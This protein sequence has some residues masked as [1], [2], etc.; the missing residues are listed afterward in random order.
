MLAESLTNRFVGPSDV[1]APLLT[2]WE[3]TIEAR[4]R[5]PFKQIDLAPV[6][7]LGTCAVVAPVTQHWAVATARNTEV[8]SDSTNVLALEAAIRRRAARQPSAKSTEVVHLAAA[9]RLLRP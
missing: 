8:V 2:R 9:H 7:P 3:R 5:P 4:L 1:A 6:V